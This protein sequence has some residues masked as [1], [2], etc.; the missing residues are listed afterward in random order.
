MA[1]HMQ[2]FEDSNNP[3]SK[4][5]RVAA[6]EVVLALHDDGLSE[7]DVINVALMIAAAVFV[8]IF[9]RGNESALESL[10]LVLRTNVAFNVEAKAGR[11][12]Q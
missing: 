4:H 7:E 3:K 10:L 2:I 12:V 5:L 6:R 9:P 8:G 1:N 11:P